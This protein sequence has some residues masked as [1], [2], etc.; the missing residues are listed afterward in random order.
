ML[1]V[2][3]D[4]MGQ[5]IVPTDGKPLTSLGKSI[6]VESC[7]KNKSQFNM[8]IKSCTIYVLNFT[9]KWIFTNK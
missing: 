1:S 2:T 4:A 7:R 9:V 8:K 6:F 3:R 5:Y